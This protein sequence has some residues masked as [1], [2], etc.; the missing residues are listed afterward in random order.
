MLCRRPVSLDR[1]RNRYRHRYRFRYRW[2]VGDLYSI[3]YR[4]QTSQLS[5][6]MTM[7]VHRTW[8][9]SGAPAALASPGLAVVCL[10]VLAL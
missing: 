3:L 10:A 7:P 1:Y 5:Q 2:A 4:D 9:R 8:Y 6:S